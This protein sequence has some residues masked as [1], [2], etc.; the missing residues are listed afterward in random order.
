M[1]SKT[2]SDSTSSSKEE[3]VAQKTKK[4]ST[5]KAQKKSGK[6]T[7]LSAKADTKKPKTKKKSTAK[8]TTSPSKK[9][10]PKSKSKKG[11][12]SKSKT[13]DSSKTALKV[14]NQIPKERRATIKKSLSKAKTGKRLDWD[15]A[16]GAK[17]HRIENKR[18][19]PNTIRR[20]SM[21]LL[22][23]TLGESWDTPITVIHGARPGPVVTVT[24]AIHGD[25]LVG[26]LA[27]SML[28]QE[29][30]TGSGRALDPNAMA[31]T[32]RIVPILNPP[33]YRGHSRYFPDGRDLNRQFPGSPD[34]N[35][36]SRVADKIWEN[37]IISSDYLI[38]LHSAAKGRTNLP[39]VRANLAHSG[40]NRIA[41]AFG[42]EVVLDSKGPRGT[43]R[44]NATDEGIGALT[45]EG[46]GATLTDHEAVKVAVYGVLNV[47]RSLKVIP[48]YP[49][50]P[51]FRLLASGSTWVRAEEG[52]LVD[53]FVQ[54]G[55][56]IEKDDI[57]GR[58]VDPHK[59]G[60]S[61]DILSPER[62]L[63]ICSAT[64]PFVTAGTPVGHLLPISRG[65]RLVKSQLDS[66]N[67]LI[68]SGSVEDPPWREEFEVD[69]IAIEG[70]WQ[71]GDVDSEWQ[72]DWADIGANFAAAA[73]EEEGQEEEDEE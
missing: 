60:R 41:R 73:G 72:R 49:S 3:G 71:G 42:V 17:Q 45:Y 52:G 57:I 19:K 9:S 63:L 4:A 37:L 51:R 39:Q 67:R 46:G 20:I 23:V 43:L 66:H 30:M 2:D 29:S 16:K 34:G 14:S 10:P 55:S 28:C 59:P 70:E 68:V 61:A 47:L 58:I 21:P 1:P 27:C 64:N 18:I 22:D 35:T 69:E 11:K 32:V 62:G 48:G 12:K 38:D 53:M 26:P 36:T 65:V 44:R 6:V 7:N 5:Q 13:V 54:S 50:R 31:G 33:G 25:E 15:R 56:F 24:G 8:K 40:S